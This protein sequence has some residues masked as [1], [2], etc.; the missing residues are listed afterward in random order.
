MIYRLV[1][2]IIN[3]YNVL[4]YVLH[5]AV[6]DYLL[7]SFRLLLLLMLLLLAMG[8]HLLWI[9]T[10]VVPLVGIV[11]PII[12]VV[13]VVGWRLVTL[14]NTIVIRPSWR[15]HVVV[16]GKHAQVGN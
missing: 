16:L 3:Y 5:S 15:A 6:V 7:V 2:R 9:L 11:L 12:I 4:S 14:D 8:R 1:S 13:G 10:M